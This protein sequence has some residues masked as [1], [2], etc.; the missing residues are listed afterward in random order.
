MNKTQRILMVLV[1]V[2][3]VFGLDQAGLIDL[4]GIWESV[5][6]FLTPATEVVEEAV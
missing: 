4:S 6:D 2:I 1:A 3:V 5:L